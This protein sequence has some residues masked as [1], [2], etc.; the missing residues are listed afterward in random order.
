M[1]KA[2]LVGPIFGTILFPFT[3]IPA[4]LAAL[5]SRRLRTTDRH[6]SQVAAERARNL[7][8]Y[9]IGLGLTL[10]SVLLI[11]AILTLNGGAVRSGFFDLSAIWDARETIWKGFKVNISAFMLTEAIVLVWALVV[12]VVRGLP[13]KAAAPVRF[14]ATAY[15]DV[16]R[17][18]PAIL[19]I[20]IIGFGMPRAGLPILEGFSD[21]QYGVLALSLV[22]G[23][24]VAEVYR[25]GISSIHWSQTAAARSLGLSHSRTLRY[26]VV[27]QAVRRI[28]PPL[29]NDFIGLQKDTALLSVLGTLEAF[30]RARIYANTNA[31]FSAFTGVALCFVVI[32]I[33]LARLTDWL[34]E[35]D[36]ARMRA[37]G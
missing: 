5:T 1:R 24:Y 29:L 20:A 33:P 30:N 16:F 27:P 32:T 12:A 22:Y 19:V 10:W 14:L 2:P 25:S 6:R 35:R 37:N 18:L 15:T 26:V 7:T 17:G 21:F 4:V 11:V 23:A 28:I 34:V 36:Q 31:N 13:G 9:S 8:Q 3:G